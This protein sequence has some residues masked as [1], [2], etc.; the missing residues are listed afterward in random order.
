MIVIFSILSI[1][2]TP[3]CSWKSSRVG[4]KQMMQLTSSSFSANGTGQL[5][6]SRAVHLTEF[7]SNLLGGALIIQPKSTG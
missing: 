4:D 3:T 7:E 2:S 1:E 5:I 6:C